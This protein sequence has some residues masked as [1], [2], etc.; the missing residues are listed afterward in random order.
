VKPILDEI[1]ARQHE[2]S[3]HPLI[4]TLDGMPSLASIR[5]TMPRLTFFIL[6]FQD[7]LRVVHQ[8]A[9]TERMRALT[10]AHWE[11]DRGHERWFLADLA[12]I[13]F[14]P[15]LAF[16]FS[17]DHEVTREVSF[18]L[19]GHL[20]QL[21]SE[22]ARLALTLALEAAGAEFFGRFS[23]LLERHGVRHEFEFFGE[24]HEAAEAA[25]EIH[26][27]RALEELAVLPVSPLD[28]QE[29]NAAVRHTFTVMTRLADDLAASLA[30]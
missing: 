8:R 4:R 17:E 28:M 9:S 23:R 14:Q 2:L 25:H 16:V 1:A 5:N 15:S 27:G 7:I 21:R 19:M 11:E 10:R 3:S 22:E 6:T 29:A 24:T 26:E 13:G 12:R 20:L 18:A 30:E